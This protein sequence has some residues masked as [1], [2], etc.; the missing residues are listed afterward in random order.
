MVRMM[1]L[2]VAWGR[3]RSIAGFVNFGG[4]WFAPGGGDIC[5]FTLFLL[6][7]F[8]KLHHFPSVRDTLKFPLCQIVS[9]NPNIATGET[10]QAIAPFHFFAF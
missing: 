3:G 4:G 6:G 9:F 8:D 1:I 5:N 10:S 2:Y 7:L